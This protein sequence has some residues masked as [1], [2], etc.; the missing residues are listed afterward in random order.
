MIFKHRF[1]EFDFQ[2][3]IDFVKDL[4]IRYNLGY[5][6][7]FPHQGREFFDDYQMVHVAPEWDI[8]NKRGFVWAWIKKIDIVRTITFEQFNKESTSKITITID[9]DQKT[10]TLDKIENLSVAEIEDS[11]DKY[12]RDEQKTKSIIGNFKI[13][14]MTYLKQL[15]AGVSVALI[16]AYFIFKLGWN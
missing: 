12:F 6:K 14:L 15:L 10:I 7:F 16:A 9:L 2:K 1:K 3:F 5:I 4:V 8:N 11:L 13:F